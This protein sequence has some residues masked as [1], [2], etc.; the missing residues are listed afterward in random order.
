MTASADERTDRD[1][2]PPLAKWATGGLIHFAGGTTGLSWSQ[3]PCHGLKP[4]R[5]PRT[6]D[7]SA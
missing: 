2:L 5:L 4:L 6:G 7:V 1:T 3:P